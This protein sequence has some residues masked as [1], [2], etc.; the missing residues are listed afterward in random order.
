MSK[1]KRKQ[2]LQDAARQLFHSRGYADVSIRDVA[3]C[4]DVPIGAVYYY[5]NS[6]AAMA[7]DVAAGLYDDVLTLLTTLESDESGPYRKLH[8]FV[9]HMAE[10][11]RSGQGRGCPIARLISHINPEGHAL[12]NDALGTTADIFTNVIRFVAHQLQALGADEEGAL[13][14]AKSLVTSWQGAAVLAMSFNDP[15][16]VA[17]ELNKAL[18]RITKPY[19]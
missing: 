16:H 18:T 9:N 19:V 4:A 17:T 10:V 6:K 3:E 8:S 1:V 14:E 2:R 7:A 11:A 5:Y 12:E 13:R 15:E